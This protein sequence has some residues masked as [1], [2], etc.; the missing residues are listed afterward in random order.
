MI[1]VCVSDAGRDLAAHVRRVSYSDERVLLTD[2]GKP[3]AALVS[4]ADAELLQRLED[5][6]DAAILRERLNDDEAPLYL[7]HA[8][9][10]ASLGD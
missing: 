5:E 7:T 4:A 6:A 2:S 1:E 10:V 9:V 8:E 3:L